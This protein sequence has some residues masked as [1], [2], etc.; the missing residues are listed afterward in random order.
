MICAAAGYAVKS[1]V[2]SA[3]Q[4]KV[5]PN[6]NR[7]GQLNFHL[8]GL[9]ETIEHQGVI[10]LYNMQSQEVGS[11]SITTGRAQVDVSQLA[12]GVYQWTINMDGANLGQGKV[13]IF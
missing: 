12:Q 2:A 8:I 6:P 1:D 7:D 13:T 10:K 3:P 9:D 5:Y 11:R 4:V